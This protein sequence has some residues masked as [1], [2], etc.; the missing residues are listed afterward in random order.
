MFVKKCDVCWEFFVDEE[1]LDNMK[2]GSDN[3]G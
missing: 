1:H 3:A 2:E